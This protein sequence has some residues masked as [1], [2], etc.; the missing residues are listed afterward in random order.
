MATSRHPASAAVASSRLHLAAG[1]CAAVCDLEN[2][3]IVDG[4]RLP[5]AEMGRLLA[6]VEARIGGMPVRVATGPNVLQPYMGLL[7]ST[8]WG[9]TLVKTVP[10]AA[11]QALATAAHD[12]IRCGI[13]D[14]FVVSGDH[15]FAS[16]ASHAR[17]HVLSHASH[18]SATLRLAATT[19]T[20]LPEVESPTQ[21]AS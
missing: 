4:A 15:A 18:L 16:L 1:R 19:V 14:I 17:L 6:F 12:F 7:H 8:C 2:V 9:L 3:A 11:D 20:Y 13:T 10:D 21:A 5:S